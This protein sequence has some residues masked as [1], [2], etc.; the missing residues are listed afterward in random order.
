MK[1]YS[2]S[3]TKLLRFLCVAPVVLAACGGGSDNVSTPQVSAANSTITA[4]P[5]T[6]TA[7]GTAAAA[8]TVSLRDT[9]NQPYTGSADI[10]VSADPCTSCTVH[11]TNNNGTVTGTLSS[12]AAEDIV[13]SF[14]V[15]GTASPSTETVHFVAPPPASPN[16]LFVVYDDVGIDEVDTFGYGG[17]N[18]P[19]TPNL[20]AI[21]DAGVRF[22]NA[23]AMPECTPSRAMFFD[24]RYSFRTN[25]LNVI[26]SSVLANS[27]LSPYESITPK[28]LAAKNYDNGYFGKWHL[29]GPYNNPYENGTPAALGLDYFYGFI[30]GSPYPL[31]TTAGGVG[32]KGAYACGFVPDA[33]QPS[34]SNSGACYASPTGPCTNMSK[35]ETGVAPGLACMQS[36]GIF[37]PDAVCQATPPSN[38]DFETMNGYYVSPLVINNPDG[39][40]EEVP[41]TDPRSRA[42]RTEAE[43]DNAIAW[44][45]SRPAG[46]PWMATVAYSAI[47]TPLQQPPMDLLPGGTADNSD[48]SCTSGTDART[49]ANQMIEAIDHDLSRLLT[50]T[51]LATRNSDGDLVYDP[52]AT[53]TWVIVVGDNGSYAPVVRAPFDPSRAKATVYQT[54]VW[55][56][57]VVAGPQVA[58]PGRQE[59]AMVNAADL[60]ELFGEIAGIDVH[61]AVP[62]SHILDSKPMMPYL[63]D[64]TQ[65]EIRTTNFTQYGESITANGEKAPPCV[66]PV[67]PV[68][69]CVQLFPQQGL[70]E[71][72]GGVWYGPGSGACEAN[73][74]AG[75][76]SCC[77]VKANA[78]PSASILADSAQA[79][80]NDN[81][82]LV[83][84]NYPVCVDPQTQY[85][86]YRIN[87]ATPVPMLDTA[88]NNL[89]TSPSLPP[90]GLTD[91]QLE[92]FNALHG[93]MQSLL[94]SQP[95]C[96][97]DGNEDMLVNQE[98]IN[99]W[100]FFSQ[101]TGQ[102]NSS[103]YDLNFDGL[104]NDLDLQIIQQHLGADC[105]PQ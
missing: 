104:T 98:D 71:S 70:C 20:N 85:E 49:L 27:Q 9:D 52:A 66:V 18:P 47:H 33:S 89:L 48:L 58:D 6:V 30:E 72:E 24:G 75:C 80:R 11:Y 51:G 54:G 21:A 59:D 26:T 4:A 50:E 92:N 94:S 14:T 35:D 29:A 97:G 62:A 37:V 46:K 88:R 105:M 57:L 36:G 73:G 3:R 77:D 22:R 76:A 17:T 61:E 23:W 56:P 40:V 101:F 81:Y 93:D 103:W 15:N 25:L 31:D 74:D 32:A 1:P 95:N 102:Q 84:S 5:S 90:Q 60:F 86:F 12:S 64:P 83:V 39:S 16:I 96:P 2:F 45:N 44:I 10:V 99:N 7:D 100:Q 28:L 87:E 42:Y 69:I 67:G 78:D 19:A 43:T 8:I 13:L 38:L 82:K 79:I 55:V 68:N 65:T 63:T 41:A 34:G 91:G 53:N